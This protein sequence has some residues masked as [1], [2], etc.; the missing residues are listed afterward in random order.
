M[1]NTTT[2]TYNGWKNWETWNVALFINNDE[3]L[4]SVAAKS[5]TYMEFVAHCEEIF[6]D[7]VS[8]PDGADWVS[9]AIDFEAMDELISEIE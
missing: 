7:F 2:Q 5:E 9:N 4:Y 3:Y 6:L 1:N 8:T